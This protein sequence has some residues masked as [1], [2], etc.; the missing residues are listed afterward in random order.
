LSKKILITGATGLIGRYI[1]KALHSRG[2]EILIL[3]KNSESARKTFPYLTRIT[4]WNDILNLK[5]EKIDGIIHLAGMNLG[6]KRWNEKVKKEL[7]DSRINTTRKIVE[8]ISTM[9]NKPEVLLSASGVDY[10]GDKG[11]EDV[12]EDS[13]PADNFTGQ[14]C[15][16]WENEALK[17]EKYGV[18]TVVIRTGFVIAKNSKAVD[19]LTLPF[20][21]F[22]GGTIGRGTQY[23]S[24]IHIDDLTGIYLF[25]LDNHN[26]RGAINGTA[27][28]PETVKTFCK[29]LAKALHRPSLF[30]VPSFAVK[31]IAG[32]IAQ[33]ILS[34]RK[35]LPK[36]IIELGYKFQFE[37]A[38][39][40]WK[41]VLD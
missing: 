25:A 40:A 27:P 41:D 24:W 10:Y 37:N 32:E 23:M 30:P 34:G 2:D 8:L 3:T 5:D 21:M 15:K 39:D 1:V 6:D 7:Y 14:L 11:S 9:Q 33:M 36:K 29:N 26:V 22:I 4:E 19:K 17:A 18:R 16:D 35:A 31:I 13:P 38:L 28:N 20:K 12:Y